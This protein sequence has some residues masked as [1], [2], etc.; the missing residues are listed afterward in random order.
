MTT[1][2]DLRE[3]LLPMLRFVAAEYRDRTPPGYP[4]VT[5]EPSQGIV[6]ITL[7]P[8]YSLFFTQDTG[9]WTVQMTRRNPRTD[10][11]TSASTMRHGGAPLNDSRPIPDDVSDQTIRNLI[12]ELKSYF[13]QQPGLI[14]IS[15]S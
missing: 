8:S 15:D 1:T 12:A 11:R 14:H 10:A 9:G 5:D 13:N 2:I 7:D 6:G 4:E 3:R